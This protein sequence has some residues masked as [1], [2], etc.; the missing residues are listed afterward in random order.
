MGGPYETHSSGRRPLV[1]PVP[2]PSK[3][4][5]TGGEYLTTQQEDAYVN[6]MGVDG[7]AWMGMCMVV[8]AKMGVDVRWQAQN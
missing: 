3:A 6:G 8:M 1:S 2:R 7:D 5:G 4:S